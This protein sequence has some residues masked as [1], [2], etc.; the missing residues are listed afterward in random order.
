M[1]SGAGQPPL[2]GELATR[3]VIAGPADLVHEAQ[4]L[5]NTRGGKGFLPIGQQSGVL[6]D[7]FLATSRS[8]GLSLGCGLFVASLLEKL[9]AVQVRAN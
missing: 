9:S 1:A 3:G 4:C 7:E 8:G 6:V 5:Q 2:E